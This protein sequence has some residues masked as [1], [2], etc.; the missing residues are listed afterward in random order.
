MNPARIRRE[1]EQIVKHLG[2]EAPPLAALLECDHE[3]NP[4]TGTLSFYI[5]GHVS[6]FLTDEGHAVC[7]SKEPER[8]ALVTAWFEGELLGKQI[9]NRATRRARRFGR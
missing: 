5:P 7:Y 2:T 9:E 3:I 1:A 8:P 4:E 6:Y